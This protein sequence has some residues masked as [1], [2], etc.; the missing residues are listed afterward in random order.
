ML[1]LDFSAGRREVAP[2]VNGCRGRSRGFQSIKEV[3]L[4]MKTLLVLALGLL[5]VGCG[6]S[7]S[8]GPPPPPKPPDATT[9]HELLRRALDNIRSYL[10][11]LEGHLKLSNAQTWP[12]EASAGLQALGNIRIELGTLRQGLQKVGSLESWLTDLEGKLSDATTNNWNEKVSAAHHIVGN[13]QIE[14]QNLDQAM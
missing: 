11:E 14:L 5:M 6:P 2:G 12:Q 3:R 8:P 7:A 1:A 13:I 9:E 10:A 4:N